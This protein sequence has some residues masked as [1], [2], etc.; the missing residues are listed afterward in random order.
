MIYRSLIL[1]LLSY[2]LSAWG[3][4]ATIHLN[5]ILLLQKRAHRLMYFC[6]PRSHAVPF[7]ILPK[8]LP[9]KMLY[10][11]RVL[12]VMY[13]VSSKNRHLLT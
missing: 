11:T 3:Q 4:A 1:P 7:F 6:E 8:T 2:G 12:S 9:L 10:L 13:D 5:K